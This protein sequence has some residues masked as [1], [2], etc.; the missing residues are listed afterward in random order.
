MRL[1]SWS[2]KRT[3]VDLWRKFVRLE[4]SFAKRL[5]AGNQVPPTETLAVFRDGLADN[6]EPLYVEAE[7][8]PRTVAQKP[9]QRK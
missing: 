4:I 9:I 1:L 7:D 6:A 2:A 5:A 8:G 3:C